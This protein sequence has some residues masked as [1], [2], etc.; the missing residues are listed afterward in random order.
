MATLWKPPADQVTTEIPDN[1]WRPPANAVTTDATP[2]DN[3]RWDQKAADISEQVQNATIAPLARAGDYA[4]RK[5]SKFQF[6][7]EAPV[8]AIE[9]GLGLIGKAGDWLGENVNDASNYLANKVTPNMDERSREY[10]QYGSALAGTA[11]SLI[12]A[13][14]IPAGGGEAEALPGTAQA[15]RRAIG[16]SKGIMKKLP[17]GV[18]QAN[19]AGMEMLEKGVIGPFAG[20]DTMLG[21]AKDLARTSGAPVRQ[22]PQAMDAIATKGVN[23]TDIASRVRSELGPKLQ[24]GAFKGDVSALNEVIDTVG[25]AGPE[26]T[27]DQAQAI[28]EKLQAMGRFPKGR[29]VDQA[30]ADKINMYRRASGIFNQHMENA[31]K[32]ESPALSQKYEAAKSAYGPTANAIRGLDDEYRAEAGNVFPTLR[33]TISASEAIGR[34]EVGRAAMLM[35]GAEFVSRKGAQMAAYTLGKAIPNTVLSPLTRQAILSEF[36]SRFIVGKK[37]ASQ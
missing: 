3:R 17:G 34:G 26:A 5:F 27:F 24:K 21:R 28:K 35:G 6:G 31:I 2:P 37:G 19:Q 13:A 16:M 9:G 11:A 32:R 8:N 30:E 25:A 10:S 23:T 4:A 18:E 36:I 20:K 22:I 1:G 15:A 12:P 33:G 14:M 7:T 29:V